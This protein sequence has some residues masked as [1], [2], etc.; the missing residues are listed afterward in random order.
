[1]S[2]G[3]NTIHW[4][5]YKP[6]FESD[7]INPYMMIYS[8]W[9][10]HRLFGYDYVASCQ[11]DCIVEL[12]SFYGCS[13]FAFLQAIKDFTLP[14][15]FY[16]VDTWEGDVFTKHDYQEDIYGS[17]M[18]VKDRIFPDQK[19]H[20]MRMT[21]DEAVNS[22]EDASIDL[23]HIDGSHTYEAVKHDFQTWRKKVKPDGAIFFHDIGDDRLN[24]KH[25]GSHIFWEELK[26]EYSNTLEFPFSFGLGVLVFNREFYH[27]LKNAISISYYQ[28]EENHSAVLTR[29]QVRKQFFQLKDR[30]IYI[31]SLKEQVDEAQ[32]ILESYRRTDAVRAGYITKIET[33]NKQLTE[34]V[35]NQMD[36]IRKINERHA[37]DIED[38]KKTDTEREQYIKKLEGQTRELTE[39]IRGQMSDISRINSRYKSDLEDYRK[40]ETEKNAYIQK[41]EGQ[42]QNL[43]EA[44]RHQADDVKRINAEYKQNIEAYKNTVSGKD[45]YIQELQKRIVRC[46]NDQKASDQ[47]LAGLKKWADE[48]RTAVSQYKTAQEE[49]NAYID[50]L[51]A[52]NNHLTEVIHGQMQDIDRINKE[53]KNG[54]SSYQKTVAGKEEYITQL[55]ADL[56]KYEENRRQYQK[57]IEKYQNSEKE[58]NGY[59]QKLE[60]QIGTLTTVI[61]GQMRDIAAINS[62]YAKNINEYRLNDARK[63]DYI[64]QIEAQINQLHK[65][66]SALMENLSR[67]MKNMKD[68]Q[69]MLQ[70]LLSGSEKQNG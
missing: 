30:D 68:D 38:Y 48:L 42:V 32:K 25:L 13:S 66:N 19:V 28:Q 29:D 61:H 63:T 39:K 52:Q 67:A 1:M 16:A 14:C 18:E 6:I 50:R 45:Q 53:Y 36:D 9:S 2:N 69:N 15:T 27:D 8:P 17:F 4:K 57:A 46:E 34:T 43:T 56:E 11:P 21:F 5:E 31:A 49:R 55:K 26:K 12:G 47:Q 54:I 40:T 70:R 44:V 41:L 23:L 3:M 65:E 10:G 22:F 37:S 64:A 24:G 51:E 35:R 59:I 20:V 62:E 7:Q 58:R 60:K 33:Q